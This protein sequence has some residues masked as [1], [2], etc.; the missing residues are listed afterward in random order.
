MTESTTEIQ[1]AAKKSSK[2]RSPSY[3]ATP[4]STAVQRAKVLYDIERRNPA[5]IKAIQ[6]HWG[7]KANT[8]P[9]NLAVAAL[10]KYGLIADSGSGQA[11]VAHLTQLGYDVVN[12]PDEGARHAAIVKAALNPPIHR[13]VWERYSAEGLPSDA[14]LRYDLVNNR[15][16]TETGATEFIAQFR[17]T[18]AFANLVGA[19]SVGLD[20]PHQGGEE[21][22][23]DAE[24]FEHEQ[25]K[26]QQRRKPSEP[27]VLTI[28]VPIIGGKPVTIEGQFPITEAAWDQFLAV[29]AAMKPGLV[30]SDQEPEA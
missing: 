21:G 2:G 15:G 24:E 10:K 7:F 23:D 5:P 14:T 22:D 26:P 4:L 8:G 16:F 19:T 1:T 13:A 30:S 6:E 20:N 25:P 11:R 28:P 17:K 12:H 9:A 27:G 3:P 18:V 29:L